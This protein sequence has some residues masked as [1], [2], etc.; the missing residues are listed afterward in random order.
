MIVKLCGSLQCACANYRCAVCSDGLQCIESIEKLTV[1]QVWTPGIASEIWHT[2][3]H[4]NWY[5]FPNLVLY[6]LLCAFILSVKVLEWTKKKNVVIKNILNKSTLE[7]WTQIFSDHSDC[8]QRFD[9]LQSEGCVCVCIWGVC[10]I[11]NSWYLSGESPWAD[12]AAAIAA[13]SAAASV[14]AI[15]AIPAAS[16]CLGAASGSLVQRVHP[17]CPGWVWPPFLQPP[18]PANSRLCCV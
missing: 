17:G 10:N 2:R 6:F 5:K 16:G 4:T 9:S 14:A 13:A 12:A 7:Q 8:S 11:N 18:Q 1:C 3:W 15:A